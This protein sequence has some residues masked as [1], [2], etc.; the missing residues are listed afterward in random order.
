MAGKI[1]KLSV[2]LVGES[3]CFLPGQR[4]ACVLGFCQIA[5]LAPEKINDGLQ[6]GTPDARQVF[7][8]AEGREGWTRRSNPMT[9]TKGIR[10]MSLMMENTDQDCQLT[11]TEIRMRVASIKSQWSDEERV[12][13][14]SE[15]HSRR[16]QLVA[17]VEEALP[18]ASD[19]SDESSDLS[20]SRDS[21]DSSDSSDSS[22]SFDLFD[23]FRL[24]DFRL[25]DTELGAWN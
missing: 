10:A 3:R 8:P 9:A 19:R 18:T 24:D 22:D 23:D 2:C 16:Q 13:R 20:N 4:P 12:H 14:A 6:F 15:G 7:R 5:D 1:N 25:E 21:R 11:L 17:L